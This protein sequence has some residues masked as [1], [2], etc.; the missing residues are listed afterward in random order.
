[1][2]LELG[3][4]EIPCWIKN[5]DILHYSEVIPHL[6][7]QITLT[8]TL[9]YAHTCCLFGRETP[10]SVIVFFEY[11][12]NRTKNK[13]IWIVDESKTKTIVFV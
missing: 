9:S 6:S 8:L 11:L 3:G 12:F 5:V 4:E 13:T 10:I 1:M 2:Q 7:G